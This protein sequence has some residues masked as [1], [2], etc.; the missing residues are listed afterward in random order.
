MLVFG[1]P[2]FALENTFVSPAGPSGMDEDSGRL[3]AEHGYVRDDGYPV[4]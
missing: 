1:D 2:N 3:S 4:R